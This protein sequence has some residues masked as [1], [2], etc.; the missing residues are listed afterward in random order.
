MKHLTISTFLLLSLIT[1][2]GL[3]GGDR[4]DQIK[5]NLA[6]AECVDL[7]FLSIIES[8]IFF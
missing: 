1:T 8:D 7:R 3:L 4:F 2:A 5:K 6:E